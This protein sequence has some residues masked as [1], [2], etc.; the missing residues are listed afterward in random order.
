MDFGARAINL[1]GPEIN[2]RARSGGCPFSLGGG[3]ERRILK[4]Q[5][6]GPENS[7]NS[8]EFW[9]RLIKSLDSVRSR[10]ARCIVNLDYKCVDA[11]VITARKRPFS[12]CSDFL[13][14]SGCN[15]RF[16]LGVIDCRAYF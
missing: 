12:A 6:G 11:N 13:F 5:T 7:I 1:L 9:R 2:V 10:D 4:I 8:S 16:A 15:V 3:N 14:S